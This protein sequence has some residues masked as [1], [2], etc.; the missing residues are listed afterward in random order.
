MKIFAIAFILLTMS[1]HGSAQSELEEAKTDLQNLKRGMLL[2]RLQ[3]SENKIKALQNLGRVDEAEEV[4]LAQY[5]ENKESLL[6]F[7]QAFTFCPVY[8][9]YAADS[10]AIMEGNLSG[11]IFTSDMQPVTDTDSL[12]SQFFTGEFSATT[13]LAIAGF[14]IMDEDLVPLE[15]PFPFYQR[16]HVIFGLFTLSKGEIVERLNNKLYDTYEL[17][18]GF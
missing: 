13:N 7:S 12:P 1:V 16:K 18:F 9:F 6:A 5:Q 17:W 2:V 11:H 4:A 15:A 3:T 14:I 10:E 8:F